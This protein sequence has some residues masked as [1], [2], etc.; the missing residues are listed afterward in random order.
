V[1]V[2]HFTVEHLRQV[3]D[4]QPAQAEILRQIR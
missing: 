1:T 3:N 4:R 2:D